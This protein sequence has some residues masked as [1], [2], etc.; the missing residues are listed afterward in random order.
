MNKL[1]YLLPLLLFSLLFAQNY[2]IN[3]YSVNSGG[4]PIEGGTYKLNASLAQTSIGSAEG[5]GFKGF[6]GFWYGFPPPEGPP[7]PTGAWQK[8]TV[9]VPEAPSNKKIKSGGL[10]VYG[11]DKIY[12]VKGNNTK[13]FYAFVPEN[14]PTPLD[15]VPVIGK[16][17]VK[18]GTG[19]TYDGTKYLYFASGTNTFQFWRYDTETNAW[20]SLPPVPAGPN[21]KALKG[22]TGMAYVNG[23]VYLLKGSKTNEFYAFDCANNTWIETLPKAP[24]GSYQGKGYGD[25]SCLIAYDNNTLYAL[26]GKYN[27]FY[28]YNIS[29]NTWEKDSGMPFSHP[30]WGKKK[31]V[32]EGASM[33]LKGGKIYAFKGNNTKEFWSFD[34]ATK[35]AGLETIPKAEDKK[36]V[37]GGGGLCT[38]SDGTIYALKGNNTTSIWKYTGS[39]TSLANLPN[40]APMENITG[41]RLSETGLKILP[42][43]TKGLTKVYYNL[44]KKEMATLRIYNTLGSVV[45]FARSD[46]GEFT[47]KKLPAGIYLLRFESTGYKEERKLIVVK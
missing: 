6:F 25:G 35:W 47:I 38:W 34:P 10:I 15:S 12:I 16:K 2:Q 22:G 9:N 45:Y 39:A 19:I 27:E 26:R 42:N 4:S 32:G 3:W 44:P 20:E 23:L 41:K 11:G 7:P 8:L 30:M 33:T 14:A 17:G 21:N 1:K 46:K 37:K 18:K 5:T 31:K 28:K 24:E 13:D 36:Y 43:P 29:A 40:T